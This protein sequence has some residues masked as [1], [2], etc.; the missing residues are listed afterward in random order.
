MVLYNIMKK[1][2]RIVI[3][4]TERIVETRSGYFTDGISLVVSGGPKEEKSLEIVRSMCGM[5]VPNPQHLYLI[6]DDDIK[7]NDWAY[8]PHL[9]EIFRVSKKVIGCKKI[10]ASTDP[11]LTTC[12]YCTSSIEYDHKMGCENKINGRVPKIPI[13]FIES[14]VNSNGGIN[15]VEVEYEFIKPIQHIN[16]EESWDEYPIAP[17][18]DKTRNIILNTFNP[19]GEGVELLNALCDELEGNFK[20]KHTW[21]LVN[22]AREFVKKYGQGE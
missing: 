1:R 13:K 2:C 20:T 7:R 3:L 21:D 14:Y 22:E 17:K 6:S 18:L 8:D 11:V 15:E 10:I 4:S 12:N 5:E 19:L 16:E 9:N